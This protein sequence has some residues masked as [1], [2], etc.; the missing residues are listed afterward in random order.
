MASLNGKLVVAEKSAVKGL[1]PQISGS[2]VWMPAQVWH[3]RRYWAQLDAKSGWAGVRFLLKADLQSLSRPE[4]DN[5]TQILAAGVLRPG[6]NANDSQV[7]DIE[8]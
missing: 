5:P 2:T 1:Q 3:D 4:C 7:V 6:M 8:P